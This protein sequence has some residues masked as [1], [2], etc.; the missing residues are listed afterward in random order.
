MDGRQNQKLHDED[1]LREFRE[2]AR[3]SMNDYT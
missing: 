3:V 1:V 2:L